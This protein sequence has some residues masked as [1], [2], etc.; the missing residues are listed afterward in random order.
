LIFP[1]ALCEIQQ[2]WGEDSLFCPF[3]TAGLCWLLCT[4]ISTW[5]QRPMAVAFQGL[6]SA[7]LNATRSCWSKSKINTQGSKCPW[8]SGPQSSMCPPCA[9]HMHS[10]F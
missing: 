6:F 1:L 2:R 9:L 7:P 5:C 8:I 4:Q 10:G 3:Q